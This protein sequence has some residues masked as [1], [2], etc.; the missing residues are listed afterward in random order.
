M[1]ADPGKNWPSLKEARAALREGDGSGVKVA[2]IDSGIEVSHPL[3]DG[4]K[5]AD[6]EVLS[7]D[8]MRVLFRKGNG[9][10]AYG[11]GTAVAGVLLDEA[12]GVTIGS[13]QALDTTNRSHSFVIAEAA[14]LAMSK[15]Y[16]II[17]C[18]FGC[19]GLPKYVMDYK[20][21]VDQAYLHGI[22]VVAASGNQSGIPE[23]PASFPS[24]FGVR[25]IKCRKN[26]F[27]H[28]EGALISFLAK[29]ERVKV[30]WINGS[31]KLETGSSFA[32]PRITGKIARLLSVFPCVDPAAIKPLLANLAKPFAEG[33]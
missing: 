31:T 33:E 17:N 3:L 7:C 22:Q 10:D 32:A 27:Y 8:G 5:L 15:G 11:H 26:E 4:L 29:G 13:F 12:P 20:E 16:R 9:K 2:I 6:D 30:P 24:V 28:R 1:K 14:L 25:A 19:R 23:W 21:W 18:S